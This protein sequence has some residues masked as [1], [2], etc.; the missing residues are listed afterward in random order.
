MAGYNDDSQVLI[1]RL[2]PLVSKALDKN[3][4]N[5]NRH[6]GNFFNKKNSQIHDIAPYTNILYNKSDEDDLFKAIGLTYREVLEIIQDCFF[7]KLN[8]SPLCAKEPYVEVLICAIKYYMKKKDM[9]NAEFTTLYLLFTGKFYASLYYLYFQF[10][11]KREIMDYVI[12][13]MLTEKFDLKKEKTIFGAMRKLA[14]TWLETYKDELLSMEST[15]DEFGKRFI[16]QLRDR[17]N[18]FL[19]NIANLYYEASKNKLY[20]NYESDDVSEDNFRLTDNDAAKASRI[21]EAA[22]NVMTS[23]KVSKA[24]CTACQDIRN[25]VKA[26]YIKAIL[27]QIVA[28]KSNIPGIRRV[29]NIMIIDFLHNNP[30]MRVASPKFY[31]YTTSPK[32]NTKN[33]LLIEMK[34]TLVDWLNKYSARYRN[35]TRPGTINAYFRC[36]MVYF[37]LVIMDAAEKF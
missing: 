21:T 25:S 6:I 10:T 30:G 36:M 18:S 14:T 17:E 27:E 15:D 16:Q 4:L 22:V 12:N 31:T 3:T 19:K 37:S 13:N 26:E 1:T 34:T 8:Y 24:K 7:Y 23:Q 9:K 2:Y 35:T 20:L 28:D 33:P 5:L 11:P 29:I 32:S